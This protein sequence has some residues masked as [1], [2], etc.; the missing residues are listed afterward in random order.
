MGLTQMDA[1]TEVYH[2]LSEIENQVVTARQASDGVQGVPHALHDCL[3]RLSDVARRARSTYVV[4]DSEDAI[5]RQLCDLEDLVEQACA[6][7]CQR[8]SPAGLLHAGL[9]EARQEIRDLR[10]QLR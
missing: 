3:A 4:A 9:S 5:A 6:M 2:R 1:S 8:E 7:C 10:R